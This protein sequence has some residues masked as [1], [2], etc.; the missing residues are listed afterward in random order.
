MVKKFFIKSNLS[1]YLVTTVV[2]AKK[3]T[4]NN[5]DDKNVQ[6]SSNA[7]PE[8]LNL[9]KSNFLENSDNKMIIEDDNMKN[10]LVNFSFCNNNEATPSKEKAWYFI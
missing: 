4:T 10:N 9:N 1:K 5:S 6:K 3:K 8:T 7:N 2:K